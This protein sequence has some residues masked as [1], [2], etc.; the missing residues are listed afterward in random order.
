MDFK[1]FQKT[2]KC[3]KHDVQDTSRFL[4]SLK[5]AV[6]FF[7]S[8]MSVNLKKKKKSSLVSN[9]LLPVCQQGGAD[10]NLQDGVGAAYSPLHKACHKAKFRAAEALLE[11]GE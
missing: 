9:Q 4:A 5:V 3:I 11:M 6:S 2:A 1:G 7:R 10:I 8:A